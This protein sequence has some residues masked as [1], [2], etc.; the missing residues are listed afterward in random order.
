MEE[1]V[2]EIDAVMGVVIDVVAEV[3]VVAGVKGVEMVVGV[4]GVEMVVDEMDVEIDEVVDVEVGEVID[5]GVDVVVDEMSELDFPN[6]E[7][8]LV[9]GSCLVAMLEGVHYLVNKFV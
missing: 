8:V 1:P 5:E 4:K 6:L 2:V 9:V 7:V 3:D